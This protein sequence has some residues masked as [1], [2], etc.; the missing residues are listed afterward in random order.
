MTAPAE[1]L[2]T[3]L[4]NA[5]AAIGQTFIAD[6]E[7]AARVE[8]LCRD[9]R[10]RACIRFVMTCALAKAHRPE[11]DARKPYTEI[12]TPDA[13]SGRTYDERHLTPFILQ[14][15]LPC[16]ATTAFLT[17]AFRNRNVTLTPDMTMVGRPEDL[18]R[19]S[20]QLATDMQESRVAAMDVLREA[21]RLLL[22]IRDEQQQRLNTLLAGLKP[23]DGTSLLSAEAIVTLIEQHLRS[24]GSSRLPVLIVAAAYQVIGTQLGEAARSLQGHN[25]ADQQTGALGDLEI[26]L[27]NDETVITVY[28]MKMKRVTI[29]DIDQALQKLQQGGHSV[30]HYVFITTEEIEQAVKDYAASLYERT[31]GIEVVVMDC[32]S[33]LRYFL[34]LFHRARGAFLDAYQQI[35]LSEPDS[36]VSR[37]L[38]ELFLTLRQAAESNVEDI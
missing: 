10:N 15:N 4:S 32:I 33:F 13:Y 38:K 14:N 27:V 7:I 23:T 3:A 20:L 8:L 1:L 22:L 30:G 29:S 11:V 5:T 28:E 24:R 21:I 17:P 19:A 18:Y 31:N 12:R 6:T 2:Q 25:A 35:L 34:H 26:T 37:P 36:A 16:N 9:I